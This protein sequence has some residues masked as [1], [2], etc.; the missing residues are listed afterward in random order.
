MKFSIFAGRLLGRLCGAEYT[1]SEPLAR[2]LS[3]IS[4]P[5]SA[6]NQVIRVFTTP[7]RRAAVIH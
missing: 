6:D 1:G 3:N 2:F 7:D 4:E 5:A